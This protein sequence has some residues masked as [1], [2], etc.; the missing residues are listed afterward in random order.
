MEQPNRPRRTAP[1]VRTSPAPAA[2]RPQPRPVRDARETRKQA[3]LR[4]L[5]RQSVWTGAFFLAAILT[6]AAVS[7]A[8]PDRDFS[9]AENRRLKQFPV[10]SVSSLLNGSYFND[11]TSYAAEQ[12]AGR[13]RWITLDL[14][15][16]RLLGAKEAN[17]VLLCRDGYLMEPP[18][19]PDTAALEKSRDAV[20]AFAAR[21]P[22][23][24][25]SMAIVPNAAAIL[26]DRLPENVPLRDQLADI[27]AFASGLEGVQFLDVSPA[28]LAHSGEPLYYK[29]DHHW[30]TYGAR[31]A[32]EAIAP[33]LGIDGAAMSY[34]TYAV[35]ADFEGTLAAKSG[36]HD[37]QDVIEI[38]V[39]RTD[40]LFYRADE[41][42]PARLATLYDDASLSG[43]DQYAVFL[44]G[45]A[46][47][48]DIT[49]TAGTGRTLLL[50][51]DSYANCF[52]QF[53][54]PYFDRI[55]L[56]DPRYYY[57]SAD[58]VLRR[59][60]VTDVLFLYNANTFFMDRSLSEVL[61]P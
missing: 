23:L 6:L 50:F 17:G 28:L 41:G 58:D 53:L 25:V 19:A 61:A 60:S 33:A 36:C 10:F 3:R 49:T 5:Q 4:A 29:T 20:N 56:I 59:E 51:K 46:P 35:S 42:D 22:E 8:L 1:S 21:H 7:L 13:D 12:F 37:T 27:S 14:A 39:P 38:A 24:S 57:A 15:F 40:V 18:A 16:R 30:T 48:T 55:I 47:R 44:G 9:P 34:D 11:W 31:I 52:V 32:F 45:N 26:T 43:N 2:P 54:Y